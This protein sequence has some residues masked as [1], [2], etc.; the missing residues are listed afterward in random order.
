MRP[1]VSLLFIFL[2]VPV[3]AAPQGEPEPPA[4]LSI[5][6]ATGAIAVDGVLDDPGWKDVPQILTWFEVNPG[7][8]TPPKVRNVAQLTY[9]DKFFYAAFE[10]EDPHP[11]AIRAPLGDRDNVPMYTDYGGVILD[12]RNTGKTAILFLANARGIQYD[13][14]TDDSSGEDSSPDYYWDSAARITEKG[15]TLEIRIPFSSLRYAH[16]DPQTWRI[17]LYRNYPRDFR[18]QFFSTRMP[19]GGNCLVCRSNPLEGLQGLPSG[20]GLVVAPY[21]SG[22]QPRRATAWARPSTTGRPKAPAAST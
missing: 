16:A 5:R 6:R 18:Y 1:A 22:S 4:T 3:W 17:I 10:F 2:N 8:N 15:W 14:V 7:D 13:A 11:A 21:L 19:R 12:T 9:D 20:G